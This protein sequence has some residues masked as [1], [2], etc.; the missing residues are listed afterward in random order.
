MLAR[1]VVASGGIGS[2][3]ANAATRSESS[4]AMLQDAELGPD[5]SAVNLARPNLGHWSG[6]QSPPFGRRVLVVLASLQR[7]R[8]QP[9]TTN[10][11]VV[12]PARQSSQGAILCGSVVLVWFFTTTILMRYMRKP[13]NHRNHARALIQS[14]IDFP[15]ARV[16]CGFLGRC[17]LPGSKPSAA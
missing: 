14:S 3:N 4:R 5:Y 12:L 17:F 7:A 9:Q 11:Y 8:G 15:C 1:A 13:Q 16:W 2:G 6:R 10:D